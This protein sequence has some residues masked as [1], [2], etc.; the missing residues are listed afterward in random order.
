MSVAKKTIVITG[1]SDGIGAAAARR[2]AVDRHRV[3]IVGRSPAKT[4]AV[5]RDV[6]ADYFTADF[7]KLRDVR[8]LAGQLLAK[9]DRI[10]VLVNNAGA[11][12]G[13]KR[14]VTED[15]HEKT[16]QLNY[17]APFLLTNLLKDL[18]FESEATII[19]TTSVANRTMGHVD[20]DDLDN[21]KNYSAPKAYGTSKLQQILFTRELNR[22]FGA[23]GLTSV[24]FHP[25]NIASN[26]SSDPSSAFY[27]IYRTF[28]RHLWLYPPEK[29]ADTLV[30]LAEG[31]PGVDFVPGEYY[32][33]RKI[34]RPNKQAFDKALARGLWDRSEA[35]L[36]LELSRNV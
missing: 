19:S 10:D 23:L 17:L 24:A 16:F 14:E 28:M 6:G 3:V 29:G 8:F 31:R 35:M 22:R 32:V 1:A 18:L 25:G 5:A 26:F 12:F 20:I 9:Y 15:G 2:L 33:R 4:Q 34:G 27:A 30:Y 11:I 7:L 21:A 36:G 13:R